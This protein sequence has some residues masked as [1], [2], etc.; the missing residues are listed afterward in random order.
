MSTT[1]ATPTYRMR[2][3]A[4]PIRLA[5]LL[6]ALAAVA[7]SFVIGHTTGHHTTQVVHRVVV[8]SAPAP[9]TTSSCTFRVGVPC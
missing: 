5:L 8:P 4:L 7:A 1:T 9:A 2:P 6:V 3:L